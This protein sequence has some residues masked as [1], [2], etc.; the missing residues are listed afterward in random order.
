MDDFYLDK[1]EVDD[2]KILNFCGKVRGIIIPGPKR[3]SSLIDYTSILSP[4]WEEEKVF[5]NPDILSRYSAV[6]LLTFTDKFLQYIL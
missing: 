3:W 6:P 4:I 5:I 2:S 1:V